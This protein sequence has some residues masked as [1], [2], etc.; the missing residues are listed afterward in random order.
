[1]PSRE[2]IAQQ[3]GCLLK[4]ERHEG[5]RATWSV[6]VIFP[7]HVDLED[8]REQIASLYDQLV[9]A[10][11]L[12]A[13]GQV[14]FREALSAFRSAGRERRAANE[15]SSV[16]IYEAPYNYVQLGDEDTYEYFSDRLMDHGLALEDPDWVDDHRI[17]VMSG[18][19]PLSQ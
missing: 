12:R 7:A 1:V 13:I 11:R 6:S 16:L 2:R 4:L 18:P 5:D 8:I 17:V 10:S 15:P 9:C 19:E 14:P 3:F